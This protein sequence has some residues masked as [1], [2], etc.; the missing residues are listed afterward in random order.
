MWLKPQGHLTIVDPGHQTV[1]IDT[2]TCGHCNCIS[3]IGPGQRPEDCGGLCKCCMALICGPCVDKGTCAPFEKELERI[4][5]KD[6][7]FRQAG[8]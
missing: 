8:I 4:E 6:R 7:F 2:M 3:Q 1:E 5:A